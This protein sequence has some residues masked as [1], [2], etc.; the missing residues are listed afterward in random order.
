MPGAATVSRSFAHA[1][2]GAD[3]AQQPFRHWLL[4]AVLPDDI[5]AALARLPFTPPGS[6]TLGRRETHNEERSYC[7]IVNRRRFAVCDA[8]ARGLQARQA[9]LAV[10]RLCGIDLAG[11]YLRIEYCQDT[12]GF[13]LEPHTDIGAKRVT[14]LIYLSPD[15][16]SSDWG[17]DLYDS[18]LKLVDRAPYRFNAGITFVPAKDTWHGFEPRPISGIR[19][20]LIINYVSPEWRSRHELAFPDQPV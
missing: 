16:D 18:Q 17:T 10:E 2:A 8:L 14:I 5:P 6:G 19:R 4:D 9:V 1:L 13:W 7:G 15:A 20:S 3:A 12:D 11:T